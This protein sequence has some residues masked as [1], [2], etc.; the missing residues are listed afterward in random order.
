MK[1]RQKQL[2]EQF[3][4]AEREKFLILIE[5]NSVLLMFLLC[6]SNL[7]LEWMVL[8]MTSD[9]NVPKASPRA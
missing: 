4:F 2:S 9:V 7:H 8:K 5:T 6:F 3:P 1:I